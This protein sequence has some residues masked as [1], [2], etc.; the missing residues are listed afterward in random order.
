VNLTKERIHIKEREERLRSMAEKKKSP[1]GSPSSRKRTS[2][3]HALAPRKKRRK[4]E[5]SEGKKTLNLRLRRKS[6]LPAKAWGKKKNGA[7]FAHPYLRWGKNSG[8][9]NRENKGP[10]P[11]N[12]PPATKKRQLPAIISLPQKKR[13]MSAGIMG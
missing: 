1:R 12:L 8:E 13:N 5:R 3:A 2:P 9:E 6:E 7:P 11:P 4:A 10:L